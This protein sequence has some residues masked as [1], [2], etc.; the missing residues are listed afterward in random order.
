MPHYDLLIIG[1]GSGNSV[2]EPQ[3]EH[4]KIAI[5]EPGDFGGTC[6]NRGCIPSKMLVHAADLALSAKHANKLGVYTIFTGA[7]CPAIR[8]RI[9]NRIDP[10]AEA[11]L[12]YRKK[13]KNTTV[14]RSKARFIG[15]R[16]FDVGGSKITADRV[17][18][19]TGARPHELPIPGLS[20]TPFHT[21]DT[22]MR[23]DALPNHLAIIGGGFIA[24]E[25]SHIFG[26]LGSEVTI[27]HRDDLLLRR[28][29][30]DIRQRITDII[31]GRLDLRRNTEIVNVRH[32][33]NFYLD[34]SDGATISPDVLLIAT[35]RKPNS[36]SLDLDKGGVTTD[37]DGYITTDEF[38]NTSAPQVWALGDVSNP[39]QLKHTA[40]AEARAVA[41]NLTNPDDPRSV[42]Y[43][44]VPS[45]VF[46][47][48]QIAWVGPS[49]F[50]LQAEG[51][52]Y[53]STTRN[54]ANTAYGWAMEDT[55]GFIKLLGD[56]ETRRL[57]GGH[58]IGPQAS[59]LVQ[60]LV[61]GMTMGATIDQMARDQLYL[62][63]AMP[64]VIEQA[65]LEL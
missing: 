25:M 29:D 19:A 48:P 3:H 8:D 11:G 15:E 26:G 13:L 31:S 45:A 38:L 39:M 4:W 44:F 62:H 53:I 14:Y 51:K 56:P 7:D 10:I 20:N 35:G 34:L 30:L 9:F 21:S 55:T 40:N 52:S 43:S 36:D 57:V 64:E 65:L 58:L 63:P 50:Q 33:E 59:T 22:I 60:Q 16:T 37:Q 32:E 23:L 42:D 5:A 6:M 54:Y 12:T 47:N 18:I 28:A 1:A 41:H 2:I 24:L 17:V 49:E 27:I 61:Q 46:C